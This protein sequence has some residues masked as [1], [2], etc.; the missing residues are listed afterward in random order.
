M[1][2]ML[3]D[4]TQIVYMNRGPIEWC[5]TSLYSHFPHH[6]PKH[7]Y[8][9]YAEDE[10]VRIASSKSIHWIFEI[11]QAVFSLNITSYIMKQLMS[12][13]RQMQ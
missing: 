8:Q 5:V 13:L 6:L 1:M 2:I 10:T 3:P 4:K 7:R 9:R 11:R 12:G